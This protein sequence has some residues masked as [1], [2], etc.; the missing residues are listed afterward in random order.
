MPKRLSPANRLL[1]P[2]EF[3]ARSPARF[4]FRSSKK[5]PDG[6]LGAEPVDVGLKPVDDL[7]GLRMQQSQPVDLRIHHGGS[8]GC[9]GIPR[10]RTYTVQNPRQADLKQACEDG[11]PM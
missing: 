8:G 4:R 11:K 9:V 7:S 1:W 5:R 6:L 10:R 2:E 3:G